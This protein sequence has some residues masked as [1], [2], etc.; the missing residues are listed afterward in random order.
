MA[1]LSVVSICLQKCSSF[2]V[3]CVVRWCFFFSAEALFFVGS[4]GGDHCHLLLSPSS[5]SC[6][7]RIINVF[8]VGII[9]A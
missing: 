6:G 7:L 4:S 5:V 8:N 2:D 9:A 1:W 3:S